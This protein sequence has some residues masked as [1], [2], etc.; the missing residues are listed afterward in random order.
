M[1]PAATCGAGGGSADDAGGLTL[2]GADNDAACAVDTHA[3]DEEVPGPW[4]RASQGRAGDPLHLLRRHQLSSYLQLLASSAAG[5]LDLNQQG[6][7]EAGSCGST[8]PARA[9]SREAAG[10]VAGAGAQWQLP[11][12]LVADARG[13]WA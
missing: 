8:A 5:C 11:W 6:A 4:A 10:A 12:Q 7:P 13:R 9:Q 3:V 2:S 1:L